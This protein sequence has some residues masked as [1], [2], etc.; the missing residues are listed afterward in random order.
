MSQEGKLAVV[1]KLLALAEDPGATPAEAEAFTAKAERMMADHGIDAA[2]VSAL[3]VGAPGVSETWIRVQA[4]Y[5]RDKA[6]FVSHVAHAMRCRAVILGSPPS[7][8]VHVFGLETDVRGAEL[9]ISSLLLQAAREQIDLDVPSDA[10]PAAYLRSWWTG[11]GQAVF[12]RLMEA[13]ERARDAAAAAGGT[14][15]AAGVDVVLADRAAEIEEEMR[16]RYPHLRR[17]RTRQL[18]G[19]GRR[20]GYESGERARLGVESEL[21]SV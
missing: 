20:T 16:R 15:G 5:V 9:L 8:S 21:P 1:R 7:L 19:E 14:D 18:S 11:F 4:P 13:H 12:R 6:M 10:H 2:M 3:E 17:P